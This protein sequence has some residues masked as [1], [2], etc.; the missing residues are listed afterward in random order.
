[1]ASYFFS[2]ARSSLPPFLILDGYFGYIIWTTRSHLKRELREYKIRID[3]CVIPKTKEPNLP[4][5]I[6][7]SNNTFITL[8]ELVVR[9]GMNKLQH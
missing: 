7:C 3:K 1:M 2:P 6:T 8:S 5:P 9:R 4:P